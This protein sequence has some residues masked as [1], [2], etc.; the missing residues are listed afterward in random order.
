[1]LGRQPS[2]RDMGAPNGPATHGSLPDG[3]FFVHPFFVGA[4]EVMRPCDFTS[5]G[6][7]QAFAA[8]ANMALALRLLDEK[9]FAL[10]CLVWTGRLAQ[11]GAVYATGGDRFLA[12]Y[13]VSPPLDLA[14]VDGRR[15]TA[16][17]FIAAERH[18]QLLATRFAAPGAM[19]AP[20][21]RLTHLPSSTLYTKDA[22]RVVWMHDVWSSATSAPD[23]SLNNSAVSTSLAHM[24]EALAPVAADVEARKFA[25][26]PLGF[27]SLHYTDRSTEY[28]LVFPRVP[29]GYRS[30][31]PSDNIE[32]CR[33]VRVYVCVRWLANAAHGPAIFVSSLM[34]CV[35]KAMALLHKYIVHLD[36]YAS[37]IMWRRELL[38]DGTVEYAVRIIDWDTV[39]PLDARLAPRMMT[40]QHE[41]GREASFVVTGLDVMPHA[42]VER[43]RRTLAVWAWAAVY[44]SDALRAMLQSQDPGVLNNGHRE[45][46]HGARL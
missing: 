43:D 32:A 33:C 13:V 25:V 18:L 20:V 17:H 7:H 35:W 34:R 9:A 19:A 4:L 30:G 40:A 10:P 24:L 12:Y 27:A 21:R 31:L 22:T 15:Q 46:C 36:L 6:L 42:V 8:T 45:A 44:G 41:K 26:L 3:A 11:F 2:L 29:D 37:N 39:H 23:A 16:L 28:K 5:T 1:M 14:T 38:T